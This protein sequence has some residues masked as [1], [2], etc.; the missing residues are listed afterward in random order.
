[1][2]TQVSHRFQSVNNVDVFYREAGAPDAPTIL[3]LHGFPSSSHQYR[4]LIPLLSHQ[5]RVIAPDFPGFGAT[6]T[7]E[8]SEFEYTF[9]N[10][11]N[12]IDG[13]TEALNLHRFAIY[14]FDYGAPVGFRIAT[15]HPERI[16][17]IISQNG[18]AYEEG[19]TDAWAP[20]RAYWESDSQENRDVLRGL[21]A[22]QTTAWQ[23]HEGT[24]ESRKA[25]ISPDAIAHDQAILDRNADIQLDLF[26]NYKTNV[27]QY[28]VWQSYFKEHQP[29]VLAI[30]GKN[31]PFFDP[32][33]ASAF[34]RDVPQA[35][36]TLIDA[37]HFALETHLNEI[38]ESIH[39]FL[40]PLNLEAIS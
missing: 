3:L 17:A 25:F 28:P 38:A 35:V 30:W 19:L 21:L 5:Y 22:P 13:F 36:V 14:V 26:S 1:M 34:T 29:P 20:I 9:D 37:G 15:R 4:N 40:I 32:A 16:T 12:V 33:G 10:L 6:V 31:D 7:S 39:H 18:N 11:A 23:Y 2:T 24:P 27:A 8:S